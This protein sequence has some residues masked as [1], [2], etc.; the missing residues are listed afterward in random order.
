MSQ[1]GLSQRRT[2]ATPDKASVDALRAQGLSYHAIAEQLGSNYSAVYRLVNQSAPDS[3]PSGELWSPR[4][5]DLEQ[6][7]SVVEVFIAT[8][9]RQPLPL[10]GS[11]HGSLPVNHSPTHKRGFV[12][13]DDLFHSIHAYAKTEQIQVKQV[14]DLALREFFARRGSPPAERSDP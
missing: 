2:S 4:L 14:L 5:D 9:Q 3:A 7:L 12:L 11:P 8:P 1:R 13:A 6:R 10:N